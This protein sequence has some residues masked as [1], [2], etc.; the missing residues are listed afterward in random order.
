MARKAAD[1]AIG[2][3][4]TALVE[5]SRKHGR[6]GELVNP[7]YTTMDC[8]M[9]GA[10]AKHRLPL[11]ERTYRCDDCGHMSPRDKNS[12]YVKLTRAGFYP[13]QKARPRLT[14]ITMRGQP[15]PSRPHYPRRHDF[16]TAHRDRP[17]GDHHPR[18]WL[19]RRPVRLVQPGRSRR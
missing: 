1:A 6:H 18:R 12:A 9:C 5:M 13:T 14:D 17:P 4:K 3:T 15:T 16:R 2:A 11:S 7:A 19:L 8:R 10:R